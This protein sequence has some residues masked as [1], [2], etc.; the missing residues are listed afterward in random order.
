[1]VGNTSLIGVT[2]GLPV[3]RPQSVK[4]RRPIVS[5]HSDTLQTLVRDTLYATSENAADE[6]LPSPTTSADKQSTS[7]PAAQE[8]LNTSGV[9]SSRKFPPQYAVTCCITARW[10]SSALPLQARAASRNRC[11]PNSSSRVF[12]ASVTPSVERSTLSPRSSCTVES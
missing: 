12:S 2:E 8:T 3:I 9:A 4:T 10:V 7:R 11:S 1:M 5:D 6:A